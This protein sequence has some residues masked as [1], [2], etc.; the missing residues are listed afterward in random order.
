MIIVNNKIGKLGLK[1]FGRY[2]WSNLKVLSLSKS[3]VMKV[4]T[5]LE[6]LE[7]SI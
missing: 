6:I 4:T 2:D 5:L 1:A 7:S 3:I